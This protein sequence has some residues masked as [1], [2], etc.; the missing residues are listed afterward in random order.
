MNRMNVFVLGLVGCIVLFLAYYFYPSLKEQYESLSRT[1]K[2]IALVA[3]VCIVAALI[4]VTLRKGE[5]EFRGVVS[6]KNHSSEASKIEDAGIPNKVI[7]LL[8]QGVVRPVAVNDVEAIVKKINAN[9]NLKTF[10]KENPGLGF[11]KY[12]LA[13][14]FASDLLNGKIGNRNIRQYVSKI[15]SSTRYDNVTGNFVYEELTDPNPG[16]PLIIP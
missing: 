1:K 12:D 14:T 9:E 6:L 11:L 3:V 7:G 2:T 16:E 8:Y 5:F 13:Y 10:F 4:A 15:I